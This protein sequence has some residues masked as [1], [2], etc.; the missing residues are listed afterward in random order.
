M[1]STEGW[2]ATFENGR[3]ATR[4]SERRAGLIDVAVEA[5]NVRPASPLLAEF[6]EAGFVPGEMSYIK[7]DAALGFD[8]PWDRTA[9][10]EMMVDRLKHDLDFLNNQDSSNQIL[11]CERD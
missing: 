11:F 1:T 9:I 8:A 5:G 7:L 4:Q 10:D 3:L 6:A 2:T